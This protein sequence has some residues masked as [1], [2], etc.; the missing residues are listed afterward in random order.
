MKFKPEINEDP[1][2]ELPI[3]YTRIQM[4]STLSKTNFQMI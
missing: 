4:R 2:K 3:L 1:Q